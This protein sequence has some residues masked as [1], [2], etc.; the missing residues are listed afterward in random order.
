[1]PTGHSF[2]PR[3]DKQNINVGF[4]VLCSGTAFQSPWP[5]GLAD[6]GLRD[7]AETEKWC[8]CVRSAQAIVCRAYI[9]LRHSL[10]LGP[11][12][13]YFFV[14]VART[15]IMSAKACR[16]LCALRFHEHCTQMSSSHYTA[17]PAARNDSTTCLAV[18]LSVRV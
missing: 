6:Q 11:G 17:N 10:G 14:E 1:M 5:T 8:G 2:T 13:P 18:G 4:R 16:L 12:M 9:K 7:G 15:T 3:P